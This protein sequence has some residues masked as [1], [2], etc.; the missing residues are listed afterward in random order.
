[1][2]NTATFVSKIHSRTTSA[3]SIRDLI[4]H[5][6]SHAAKIYH[7]KTFKGRLRSASAR[8]PLSRSSSGPEGSPTV[9]NLEDEK[10]RSELLPS[11]LSPLPPRSFSNKARRIMGIRAISDGV[12]GS[13]K[14]L[15]TPTSN[16]SPAKEGEVNS[17]L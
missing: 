14:Y 5:V 10:T 8:A 2:Q 6:T 1:G 15:A 4:P 13:E 16:P 7:S 17:L 11:L 9:T 3:D 12:T